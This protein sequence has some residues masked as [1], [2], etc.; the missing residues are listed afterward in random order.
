MDIQIGRGVGEILFGLTETAILEM[1]GKPDKIEVSDSDNRNLMY[2]GLKFVLQFEPMNDARLGWIRVHNKQATWNTINPWQLDREILLEKLS[3]FLG[4][5]YEFEDYDYSEHYFF[6]E[7]WV[8]LQYEF[9]ELYAFNIGVLYGPDDQPQWPLAEEEWSVS[10]IYTSV[11]DLLDDPEE[12]VYTL[13]N[14]EQMAM[15]PQIVLN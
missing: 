12:D 11:Q 2:Y 7:N 1:L 15:Q 6:Q 13:E 9:G 14:G 8:E 4:E 5:P 3:Q 10:A